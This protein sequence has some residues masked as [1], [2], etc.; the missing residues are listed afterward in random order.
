MPSRT[1]TPLPSSISGLGA[2]M[3][4]WPA[5]PSPQPR[6]FL[7]LTVEPRNEVLRLVPYT[8]TLIP[9]FPWAP[10][11]ASHPHASGLRPGTASS[12]QFSGT[13]WRTPRFPWAPIALSMPSTVRFVCCCVRFSPRPGLSLL[14][15]SVFIFAPLAWLKGGPR[16]ED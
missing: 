2:G 1:S 5:S 6:P 12:V 7:G 10:R 15:G 3:E 11:Q 13:S 9:R 14:I 16:G 4:S 8:W